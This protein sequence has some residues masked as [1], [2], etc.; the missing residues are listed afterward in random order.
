MGSF[1]KDIKIWKGP[2]VQFPFPKSAHISELILNTLKETPDRVVQIYHESDSRMTCDELRMKAIRVGQNLS[3]QMVNDGDVVGFDCGNSEHLIALVCGCILIGA[4]PNPMALQHDVADLVHMWKITKPKFVFCDAEV[5][6]KVVEALNQLESDAKICTLTE[7]KDDVLFVDDVLA[8]TGF[9]RYFRPLM[10]E[11]PYEKVMALLGSSGTSGPQK[12]ISMTQAYPLQLAQMYR[13]W[14]MR[15]THFGTIAWVYPFAMFIVVALTPLTRILTRQ[16]ASPEL[17]LDLVNKY[18]IEY[19]LL[20]P[21]FLNKILQHISLPLD[22]PSLKIVVSVGA[23]ASPDLREKF[24]AT[25]PE[26]L[27]CSGYGSTE[28]I[29]AWPVSQDNHD[30]YKV[31]R[32]NP[33]CKVKI[34]DDDGNA[35]DVGER[36]EICGKSIY[37]FLVS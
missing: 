17:F 16:S 27:L 12:A 33:D 31:G 4:I 29:F 7:C 20:T 30:G 10:C 28:I 36:G 9:E 2:D 25:F 8:P 5:Y 24:K 18:Q 15:F 22:L 13:E 6:E 19:Q 23:I 37:P 34:V 32:V 21:D 35:L 1:D 11:K 3:K 26:K 14:N